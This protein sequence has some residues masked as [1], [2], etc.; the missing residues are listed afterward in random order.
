MGIKT[1]RQKGRKGEYEVLD[2]L[3]PVVDKVYQEA[4]LHTVQLRRNENQTGRGVVRGMSKEGNEVDITGFDIAGLDWLAL[5]IKRQE[6]LNVTGAWT[7]CKEAAAAKWKGEVL[8]DENDNWILER[9]PV[10]IWRKNKERWKVRMFGY[11]TCDG[12]LAFDE[13]CGGRIRCP[14]DIGIEA[15]L[16]WFE[17]KLRYEVKLSSNRESNEIGAL[18]RKSVKSDMKA[19]PDPEAGAAVANKSGGDQVL[20]IRSQ[21]GLFDTEI[22]DN[23][24]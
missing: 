24:G 11:L 6:N 8:R 2:L 22:T 13:G 12:G 3:Q 20:T 16:L 23:D 10:L 14:V 9:I 21:T 5:E 15:F 19:A 4:G 18:D 7:Q 1:W 17:M